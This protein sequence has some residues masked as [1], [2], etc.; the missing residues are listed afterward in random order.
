[1]ESNDGVFPVAKSVLDS[2]SVKKKG[3]ERKCLRVN[4]NEENQ[5]KKENEKG[6]TTEE[7]EMEKHE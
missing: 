4:Q 7:K 2:Q 3:G 6:R 1:M 5:G